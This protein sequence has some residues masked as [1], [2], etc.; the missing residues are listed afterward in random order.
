MLKRKWNRIAVGPQHYVDDLQKRVLCGVLERLPPPLHDLFCVPAVVKPVL[1][2][3]PV[4]VAVGHEERL[5]ILTHC[6]TRG[7]AQVVVVRSGLE[8]NHSDSSLALI[9]AK[10]AWKIP[11]NIQFT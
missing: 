5:D 6:N 2:D 4:A 8:L 3:P 7:L 11:Y 9:L 10:S 1:D